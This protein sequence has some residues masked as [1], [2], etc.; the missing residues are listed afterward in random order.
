LTAL[1]LQARLDSTRLPRKAML[2]LG[3][4]P[5]VFR[6]MEALSRVPADSYILCCP[7]D[8]VKTFSPLAARAGFRLMRGPKDDVLERYCAAIRASGADRIIRATG[9]NPFVFADAAAAISAEARVLDADYAAWTGLPLGAGVEAVKADALLR[10]AR[11]AKEAYEREHVCPYLYRRP[12]VFSLHRPL[13]PQKWRAPEMRLTVDTERD[14]EAAKALWDVF[15]QQ[16][17]EHS[18]QMQRTDG[19]AIIIA[20]RQRAARQQ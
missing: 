4:E 6:V 18:P 13:V 8:C 16:Q 15:G 7:D 11:E 9:D 12:E 1:V 10:A 5:L 14:W 17:T 3:G 20:A 2:I 19:E